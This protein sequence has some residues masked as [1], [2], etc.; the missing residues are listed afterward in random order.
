MVDPLLFTV[1]QSI[2]PMEEIFIFPPRFWV[3]QPTLKN[4]SNLFML[5]SDLWV[6][7]SRYLFNSLF[8]TV[9]LTAMQVV[10]ASMAAY[11]LAKHNFMGKKLLFNMVVFALLFSYDIVFIPQYIFISK[12]GW[13][14]SYIA[15]ILPSAAYSLG[16]YLMRQNLLGFPDSILESA[17]IDGASEAVIFWRIVMPAMKAVWMTMIVFAFGTLWSRTDTTFIYSEQLKSLPTL[18]QQIANSG[19]A[20]MGVGAATS[21]ILIIPPILVFIIT[22]SNVMETMANSGLKD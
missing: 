1:L 22:Q 11:P 15:L 10:F 4:F 18:M 2:K 13:A 5:A 6:P 19:I 12:L 17:R 16:L 8:V 9:A 14:D 7:F 3:N 21:V 20:R